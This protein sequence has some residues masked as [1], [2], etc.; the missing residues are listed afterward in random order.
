MQIKNPRAQLIVV[1]DDLESKVG[2]IR[3]RKTGSAL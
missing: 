2:K 1:C 3:V